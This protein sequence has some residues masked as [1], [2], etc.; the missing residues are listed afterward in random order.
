M[1]P[2]RGSINANERKKKKPNLVYL[3]ILH[4]AAATIAPQTAITAA[5]ETKT[6]TTT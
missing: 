6:T 1:D 2:D 4:V 3:W 5:K